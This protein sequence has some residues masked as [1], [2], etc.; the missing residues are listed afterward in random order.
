M[1]DGLDS[2]AL[3]TVRELLAAG[4]QRAWLVGGSVRDLL[5][6]REPED[7][8]L[9]TLKD[10]EPL[11]RH[12][13]D[14]LGGSFF[15]MSEEFRTCRVIA[16]GGA[17]IYDFAACRRA[18]VEEDLGERDFT[19]NAMAVELPGGGESIIDPFGGRKHLGERRLAA[20]S[21]AIFDHDPLRLLRA[22]RLERELGLAIDDSLAGLIRSQATLATRPAAERTLAELDR[23]L[24]APG[25]AGAVRRLDEL[26][27]LVTLLPELAALKGVEQNRYH[28]L[29]VFDHVLATVTNLEEIADS[30]GAFFPGRE[31]R[32]RKRLRQSSSG[33][34]SRRFIMN[35]AALL[36]DVA[37]PDCLTR[38]DEGNIRFLEHDRA[39]GEMARDILTRLRAGSE[40]VRAVA[41]LVAQ[42]LRLGFLLHE[43]HPS[44]R[45]RLRYLRAT[46][47]YTPE[48]IAL[49]VADR[50][51]VRGPKSS[52]AAIERHLQLSREMMEL[53]FTEEDRQPLLKLIAGDELIG[54]LGLQPGPLVGELLD[55]IHEDQRLGA[56]TS[57]EEALK[58]ARRLYEDKRPG[59]AV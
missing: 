49:S 3:T 46:A 42:H 33:E 11:A 40:T 5:L 58:L 27:L 29:D 16:P 59:G 41:L 8:D 55:R 31:E 17:P 37:K 38:D 2:P 7:F 53:C 50:L 44:D 19:V 22:V 9:V 36:H 25:V 28:H 35:A 12:L 26:G 4:G 18:G 39:G 48:A 32:L 51:A 21:G 15:T 43:P 6:G 52:E 20:V 1:A 30:P 45:A 23:L 34:V 24:G 14:K 10:P 54:E 47:P 13:A 57:R 56:V